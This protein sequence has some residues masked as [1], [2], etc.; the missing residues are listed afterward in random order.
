MTAD[1]VRDRMRQACQKAGS[2]KA[3]ADMHGISPSYLNDALGG[4][5]TPGAKILEALGLTRIVIYV[6][7]T[8]RPPA[9][10]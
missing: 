7:T 2:A 9:A 1:E 4:R 5:R 3:W 6:A 10:G 8:P